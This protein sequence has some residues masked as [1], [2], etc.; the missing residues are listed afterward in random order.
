ML[1]VVIGATGFI[2]RYLLKE[3][4]ISGHEV[5]AVSRN[6]PGATDILGQGTRIREWNG[7]NVSQL[8]TI[9]NIAEGIVNLAGENIS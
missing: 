1:V 6:A 9:L 7:L 2:G 8:A 3:L 4:E 5:I